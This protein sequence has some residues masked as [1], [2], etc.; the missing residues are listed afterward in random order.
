MGHHALYKSSSELSRHTDGTRF[1]EFIVP[2]FSKFIDDGPAMTYE[3]NLSTREPITLSV[4]EAALI[5]KTIKQNS[6][7][8]MP[9]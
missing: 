1:L 2:K 5:E 9:S 4:A 3:E 6:H 8:S 7:S